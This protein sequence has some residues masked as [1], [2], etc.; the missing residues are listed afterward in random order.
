MTGRS[1]VAF[2]V[3]LHHTRPAPDHEPDGWFLGDH[4]REHSAGQFD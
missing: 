1:P 4:S 3:P 2:R